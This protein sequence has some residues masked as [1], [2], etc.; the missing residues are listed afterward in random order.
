MKAKEEAAV[1]FGKRTWAGA[2]LDLGER[3]RADEHSARV[4]ERSTRARIVSALA[5]YRVAVA[6]REIAAVR[7]DLREM[8]DEIRA[9]NGRADACFAAPEKASAP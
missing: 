6:L 3:I 5:E 7:L 1:V 2:L 4:E 8:L 9:T